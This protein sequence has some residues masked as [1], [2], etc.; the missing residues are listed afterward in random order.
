M[1]SAANVAQLDVVERGCRCASIDVEK[2][3]CT[4]EIGD[5]DDI[6]QNDVEVIDVFEVSN[7]D[8]E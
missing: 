4:C 5:L 8:V 3:V 6:V 7:I 1:S 2:V